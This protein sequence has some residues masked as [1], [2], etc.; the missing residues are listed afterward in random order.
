MTPLLITLLP[1][2]TV[3]ANLLLVLAV[4]FG[5]SQSVRR[6]RKHSGARAAVL[7]SENVRL[8]AAIV[9][10]QVKI[11]KL[12]EAETAAAQAIAVAGGGSASGALRTKVLKMHR[13]GQTSGRIADKLRVPKGEVDLMVKVHQMATQAH[14]EAAA[15]AAEK[16]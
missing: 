11:Q 6:L 10:L 8:A 5:V 1:Y 12:E 7:E 14:E 16:G 4:L 13:L 9:E 2:L 15:P 3:A